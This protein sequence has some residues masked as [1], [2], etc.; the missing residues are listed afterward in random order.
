MLVLF[1]F[2]YKQIFVNLIMQTHNLLLA[3]LF[4]ILFVH[5]Y[6]VVAKSS[7][8]KIAKCYQ[9]VNCDVRITYIIAHYVLYHCICHRQAL[10]IE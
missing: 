10:I 8:N 1:K 2:E 4:H 5:N 7:I 9:Y 6:Y 3:I